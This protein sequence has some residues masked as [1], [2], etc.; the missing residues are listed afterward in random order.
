MD[1]FRDLEFP[2]TVPFE[3]P[4]GIAWYQRQDGTISPPTVVGG[5][6]VVKDYDVHQFC[7]AS[8]VT[9]DQIE[10]LKVFTALCI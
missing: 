1:C 10:T 2:S 8:T 5:R 7:G 9:V 3:K 6:F 4:I